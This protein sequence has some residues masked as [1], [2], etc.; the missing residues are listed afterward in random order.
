MSK[1]KS[2]IGIFFS[3]HNN[4]SMLEGE[5]LRRIDFEGYPVVN[6]DDHSCDQEKEYGR[7]IC[8][9]NNIPF[10]QNEGRGVQSATNTAIE[11]LKKNYNCQWVFCFQHDVFPLTKQFFSKFCA[12]IKK[13]NTAQVGA[14]GFN[15]L[16]EPGGYSG[17][18]YNEYLTGKKPKGWIGT[19]F[20]SDHRNRQEK[21]SFIQ[22][23]KYIILKYI[24][25]RD[26]SR[27]AG[28]NRFFSPKTYRQ[29][30]EVSKSYNGLYSVESFAWICI[31][32][33]VKNWLSFIKPTE[34][35]IFHL[36]FPD[37]AM[38]FMVNDVY[39]AV[40]AD[41]YVLNDQAVKEKYGIGKS[42]AQSARD[43]DT[44]HYEEY[45]LHL[46]NFKRRWGF[47][48]E[49]SRETY[50]AVASRYSETLVDTLYHHDS[51]MGP[52]KSFN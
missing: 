42:S 17:N 23:I 38:Q 3:S 41:L 49:L 47:D 14:I 10:I 2:E 51:R 32:F 4:Y 48:Y 8:E 6:I 12:D 26:V 11:Y 16:D 22:K 27:W 35:F 21:F 50:P 43:G 30:K 33:N 15:V 28:G 37:V 7:K 9:K 19:F 52:Y 18:G 40:L 46:V 1:F 45:G 5:S 13:R 31:A 44:L 20:L 24:Y 39:N 34:E 36:W 29:F 25:R